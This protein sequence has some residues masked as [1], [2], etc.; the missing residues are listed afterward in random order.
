MYSFH[1]CPCTPASRHC[2]KFS[3]HSTPS[4][5][6]SLCQ[7]SLQYSTLR[8]HLLK[9]LKK[10][11]K[12]SAFLYNNNNLLSGATVPVPIFLFT[13]N[14]PLLSN[15]KTESGD[16]FLPLLHEWDEHEEKGRKVKITSF[17]IQIKWTTDSS[18]NT[19][20]KEGT[21]MARTAVVDQGKVDGVEFTIFLAFFILEVSAP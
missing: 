11:K 7:C 18:R 8:R 20:N 10:K 6:R 9:C 19:R 5:A 14:C 16:P 13:I 1:P 15:T 3:T 17:L 12:A 4:T 2:P 21:L